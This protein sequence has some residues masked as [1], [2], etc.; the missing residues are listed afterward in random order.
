MASSSRSRHSRTLTHLRATS[1]DTRPPAIGSTSSLGSPIFPRICLI[2]GCL[3]RQNPVSFRPVFKAMLRNLIEW[4]VSGTAPP[5]S[6]YTEGTVDSEGRV[7]FTT[8]A[9]GNVK[10]GL[11]LPHMPT[12][13]LNGE[14]AGAPLGVY[15][16]LDPDYLNPRNLF[17]L[18]GGTFAPFSDQELT[19]RYPSKIGRAS[20][21]ERV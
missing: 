17:A 20:C 3:A 18:L 4:I 1:P 8:D 5:D 11:R 2:R 14:R 10:G 6:M 21:R 12:V 16:G 15:G 7:T 13:L 9:D 19:V